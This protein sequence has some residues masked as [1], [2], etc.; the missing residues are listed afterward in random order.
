MLNLRAKCRGVAAVT[1]DGPPVESTQ[2]P[3]SG[4]R[5]AHREHHMA[6]IQK[7]LGG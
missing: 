7:E 1:V 3:V 6:Q 4:D 5:G 2:V